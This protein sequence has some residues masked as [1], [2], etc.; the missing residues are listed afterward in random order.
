MGISVF[1]RAVRPILSLASVTSIVLVAGCGGGG[2]AV[3]SDAVRK[4]CRPG[5]ITGFTGKFDDNPVR[6]VTTGEGDG[7]GAGGVGAGGDGAAGIGAGGSLG[8]FVNVDVTVEFA[9]GEKY[10]PVRVDEQKGMVTIVPCSLQPPA[11]VTLTGAAGSGAKYYDEARDRDLSFEGRQLR[12]VITSFDKNAGLTTFTEAM[13]RRAERVATTKSNVSAKN[14]WKDLSRINAAHDEILIAINRQLPGVY[15]LDDLRR[16]PVILNAERAAA[17]SD[18]LTDDQNGKYGAALAGIVSVAAAN[19]GEE[20]SPAL[21]IN[22]QLAAD[23]ADGLLDLVDD[24]KSVASQKGAAYTFESFWAFQ[25][26]AT[27][28][29]AKKS[30]TGKLASASI[31]FDRSYIESKDRDG[32]LIGSVDI[33]HGSDGV[34]TYKETL[35]GCNDIIRTVANVRQKRLLSAISG[36]GKT[37]YEAKPGASRCE[38]AFEHPFTVPGKSLASMDSTGSI[39]RTTDGRFYLFIYNPDGSDPW[40]QLVAD[41]PRPIYV[42]L[43]FGFIWTLTDAGEIH[44]YTYSQEDGLIFDA[45]SRT[46]RPPAGTRH[47]VELPNPVVR[48]A[49]SADNRETFALTTTGEVFWMDLRDSTGFRDPTIAPL[50]VSLGGSNI[51]WISQGIVVVSCDGSFHQIA[52]AVTDLNVPPLLDRVDENGARFFVPGTGSVFVEQP[53]MSQTPIWRTT[54]QL[55]FADG[56]DL[57]VE[58]SNPA[59]LIGV[60]GSLRT[61]SGEVLLPAVQ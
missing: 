42:S 34:L 15:R 59:R 46:V 31:P 16:L 35:V 10:G 47:V 23:L 14:A 33:S 12:S 29:A 50:P 11:L 25:T 13:V 54:D 5:V 48:I 27:T 22:D 36:D 41:G 38:I 28:A 45:A 37:L 60:D 4:D 61:L 2:S 24:G 26:L 44:Q 30:G 57:P 40:W 43:A 18:A 8:Q 1:K 7:G 20:G 51:C 3:D 21:E 56:A 53:V 19:L 49:N 39:F 6:V 17:G 9:S 55:Q 52:R 32:N 58:L